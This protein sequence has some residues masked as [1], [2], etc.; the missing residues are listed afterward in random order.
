MV[1]KMMDINC[2]LGEGLNNDDQLMPLLNSCNIACGGHVGD[3]YSI[4][5]TIQL[6]KKHHVKIGA[7]PSYPD[8]ENFGR[9]KLDIPLSDL[10]V[11]LMDQLKLFEAICDEVQAIFHHIK[12]HG[13][14]YNEVAIN[15]EIAG[16]LIQVMRNFPGVSLYVPPNSVIERLAV[17]NNIPIITEAFADRSYHSNLTLVSRSHSKALL[18]DPREVLDHLKLL[19]LNGKVKTIE[20]ELVPIKA[21]TFCIHGDNPSAVEILKTIRVNLNI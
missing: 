8:R 14:L 16:L 9:K 7:H 19:V 20:G 5:K 11:S 13:A 17:E 10:K 3:A 12:P 1:Q 15:H 2:D 21:E 4:R 6:A 18:T